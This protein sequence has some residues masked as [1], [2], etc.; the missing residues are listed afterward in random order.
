MA[1]VHQS[2][3]EKPDVYQDSAVAEE[4]LADKGTHINKERDELLASLG[5]PDEGLS[6]EERRKLDKKLMWKVDLWIVPWLR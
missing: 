6:D 5:D 3:A 2:S 4:K 1:A